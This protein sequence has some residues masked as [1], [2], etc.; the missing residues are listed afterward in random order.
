MSSFFLLEVYVDLINEVWLP[1][2]ALPRNAL[3]YNLITSKI[4]FFNL[5]LIFYGPVVQNWV[6][7][8]PG[9]KF[10]LAVYSSFCI[11]TFPFLLK[12]HELM[13]C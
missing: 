3:A 7:A 8:N 6:S 2:P 13:Y 12:L 5:C 4:T 1:M 9:L 11:F 10:N